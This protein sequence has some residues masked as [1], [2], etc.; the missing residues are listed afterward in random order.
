MFSLV[1]ISFFFFPTDA[2]AVGLTVVS[3]L[4]KFAK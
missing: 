3:V 1:F 4:C 2:V